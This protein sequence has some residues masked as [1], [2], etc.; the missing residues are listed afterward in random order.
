VVPVPIN[1]LHAVPGMRGGRL[2]RPD[3][4]ELPVPAQPP[5]A[6]PPPVEHGEEAWPD[7]V[8]VADDALPD[9]GGVGG[10]FSL[11][12]LPAEVD[13]DARLDG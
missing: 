13:D 4:T 9:V 1:A 5:P 3:R 11:L 6:L 8:A 7:A 10:P 12:R 2:G